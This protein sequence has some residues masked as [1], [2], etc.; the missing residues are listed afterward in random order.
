MCPKF[1]GTREARTLD[2]IHAMD[3]LSQ[4]SYG[5]KLISRYRAAQRTYGRIAASRLITDAQVRLVESER[6][7]LSFTDCKSVVLPLNDDPKLVAE[8]ALA[9]LTQSRL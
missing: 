8:R 1:G 2:L 6:I 5:P 9:S 4:L 7:E 3:A